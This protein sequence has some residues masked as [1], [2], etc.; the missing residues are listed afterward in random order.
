MNGVQLEPSPNAY[1]EST[2]RM[3][4]GTLVCMA[5]VGGGCYPVTY[6]DHWELIWLP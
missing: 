1:K 6:R 2:R 5:A 3:V 4:T